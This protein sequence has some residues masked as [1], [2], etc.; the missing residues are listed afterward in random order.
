MFMH[1]SPST[2][3]PTTAQDHSQAR[4]DVRE[5]RYLDVIFLCIFL[6][7]SFLFVPF[8]PFVFSLEIE[9]SGSSGIHVPNS[10]LFVPNPLIYIQMC[11]GGEIQSIKLQS[12]NNSQTTK[13]NR[14]RIQTFHTESGEGVGT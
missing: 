13:N 9:H 6:T 12:V 11:R 4:P 1:T 5:E 8:I 14:T 2:F 10:S 7:L 3:Q